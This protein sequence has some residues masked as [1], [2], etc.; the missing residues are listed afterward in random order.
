MNVFVRSL[1][2]NIIASRRAARASGS[3]IPGG[4]FF[5]IIAATAAEAGLRFVVRRRR[6]KALAATAAAGTTAATFAADQSQFFTDN[7]QPGVFLAVFLPS[8]ELEPS[9]DE[10]G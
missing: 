4:R 5:V 7:L 1:E 9:L 10:R 6:A 2:R 3:R 8:I